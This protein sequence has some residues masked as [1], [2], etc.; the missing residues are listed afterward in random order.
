M[1]GDSTLKIYLR[2]ICITFL[3]L[4]GCKAEEE[5]IPFLIAP[6]EIRS[7][8]QE[9][10]EGSKICSERS[11]LPEVISNLD[12]RFGR[13]DWGWTCLPSN[14]NVISIS[15]VSKEWSPASSSEV[16]EAV[17]SLTASLPEPP[18]NLRAQ[19]TLWG[20][21][22]F[23]SADVVIETLATDYIIQSSRALIFSGFYGRYVEI[24]PIDESFSISEENRSV[25]KCHASVS[26]CRISG[27]QTDGVLYQL[28]RR[29]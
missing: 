20:A 8:L 23:P 2:I 22:E 4:S 6:A 29:P 28:F 27:F 10:L 16:I 15:E 21:P 13:T 7:T 3:G 1:Q 26:I 17:R 11:Q 5:R 19:Q 24:L 14:Q 25:A 12:A 18:L 9:A